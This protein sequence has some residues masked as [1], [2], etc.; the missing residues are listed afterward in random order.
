[1]KRT[2]ARARVEGR[3]VQ[4]VPAEAVDSG[5]QAAS[6]CPYPTARCVSDARDLCADRQPTGTLGRKEDNT[7]IGPHEG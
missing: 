6:V 7:L 5:Q 3:L 4:L 1:M 2:T